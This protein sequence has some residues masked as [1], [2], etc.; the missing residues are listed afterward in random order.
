[1]SVLVE[2]PRTSFPSQNRGSSLPGMKSRST[3][4]SVITHIR[5]VPPDEPSRDMASARAVKA[6]SLALLSMR[7]IKTYCSLRT[8]RS[9]LDSNLLCT[10]H[11]SNHRHKS[12]PSLSR[13][14]MSVGSKKNTSECDAYLQWPMVGGTNHHQQDII[15]RGSNLLVPARDDDTSA[16]LV[17]VVVA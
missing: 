12:N 10:S 13:L 16:E 6:V 11:R 2:A 7:R 9:G 15:D 14:C 8:Q 4:P 1:M 17:F 5:M 3:P